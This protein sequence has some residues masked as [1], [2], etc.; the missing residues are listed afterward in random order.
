MA[1]FEM[2]AIHSTGLDK[3]DGNEVRQ[4]RGACQEAQSGEQAQTS[5]RRQGPTPRGGGGEARVPIP[6]LLPPSFRAWAVTLADV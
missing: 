5:S 4:G 3:T 2:A 6:L 1:Q